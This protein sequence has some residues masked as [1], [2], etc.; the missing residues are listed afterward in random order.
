MQI[1]IEAK[2]G[3]VNGTSLLTVESQVPVVS[4]IEVTPA[5]A[6]IEVGN[7]LQFTATVYDQDDVVNGK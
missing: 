7:T 2:S 5:T 4:R 6:N 3:K 1:T